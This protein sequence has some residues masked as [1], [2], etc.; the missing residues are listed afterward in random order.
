MSQ[1]SKDTESRTRDNIRQRGNSLQ[2]RV[3]SGIDPVTDK[4]S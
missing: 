4:Q 1:P 2:V 3:Y